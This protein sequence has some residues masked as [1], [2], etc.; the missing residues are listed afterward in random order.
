[1]IQHSNRQASWFRLSAISLGAVALLSLSGGP[2]DSQKKETSTA[3]ADGRKVEWEGWTFTWS[4]RRL[5]GLVLTDVQF[6][7]RKVLNYAGLAEIFTPYDQGQPRPMDLN[8]NGLGDPL[9]PIVPGVDCSSGEWCKVFDAQGKE[10][11]KGVKPM[12]MMH[13]ERTG[14]NYLGAHGRAPGKTLVLWS[15]G[16]FNGGYDGYT[17]VVRWKFRDDGTLTPEIGAT[18]VPQHMAGH[19]RHV[20]DR[21]L[22]RLSSRQKEGVCSVARSCVSLSARFRGRWR[23]EHGRGI[24]LGEGRQERRQGPLHLDA[25]QKGDGPAVQS[26][27]VPVLARRQLSIEERAGPSPLVSIDAGQHRHLPRQR[28]GKSD[29]RRPVGDALQAGGVSALEDRCA[30]GHRR[31]AEVCE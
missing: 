15:A 22:H 19:R 13:E 5:E 20:A 4:L 17:F 24:Q 30:L 7:G 8:Q 16:R 21:R 3:G 29:A 31:T 12:V 26:G 9:A 10:P 14:P 23:G 6:R 11:S 28:S 18:G 2:V 25:D 27:D 1:M